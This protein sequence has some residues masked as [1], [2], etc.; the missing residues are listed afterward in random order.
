MTSI[1]TNALNQTA[2]NMRKAYD[3]RDFNTYH[4]LK[5]SGNELYEAIIA[6]GY[7]ISYDQSTDTY[8]VSR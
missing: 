4:A 6:E 7:S 1:Y 5:K 2:A 3:E 8:T